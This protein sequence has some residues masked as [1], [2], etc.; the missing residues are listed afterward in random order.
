MKMLLRAMVCC[1]ILGG[2]QWAH[3]SV[4]QDV[5]IEWED[6]TW[7]GQLGDELQVVYLDGRIRKST[8]GTLVRFADGWLE[9]TDAQGNRIPPIYAADLVT[10]TQSNPS[11]GGGSAGQEGASAENS[12]DASQGDEATDQSKASTD[13]MIHPTFYLPLSGQVGVEF[14]AEEIEAITA[15]ADELGPG[16]T[17][18]LHIDSGGGYVA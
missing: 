13:G 4:L 9:L 2:V 5:T 10:I 18:V 15:Q 3:A 12:Q 1:V 17:I 11:D 7:R 16:Q 14:R 6:G 8:S